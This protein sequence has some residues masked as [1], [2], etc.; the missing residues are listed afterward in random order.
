M[1]ARRI[2]IVVAGVV[3]GV[4]AL[5]VFLRP[6]PGA[7]DV[8]SGGRDARANA[9]SGGSRFLP[10]FLGGGGYPARPGAETPYKGPTIPVYVTVVDL[11]GEPIAGADVDVKA[12]RDEYETAG[13]TDDE[14]EAWSEARDT[15]TTAEGAEGGAGDD[16]ADE[17]GEW[18]SVPLIP[19][20]S[21][22]TDRRGEYIVHLRP[23]VA[24]VFHARDGRGREGISGTLYVYDPA[25]EAEDDWGDERRRHNPS[26]NP[27]RL[28]VTIEIAELSTLSGIVVD[29]RG[30]PIPAAEITLT[31]WSS[32]EVGDESL[33][34][35]D[36]PR[37][38]R[39]GV[40]TG[41]DG[42][43][44]VALRGSGAFDLEAHATGFQYALEQAI[45]ILPGR[46]TIVNLTLL[47]AATLT[48]VVVGPD[49]AGLENSRVLVQGEPTPGTFVS[50]EVT[51]DGAGAFEMEG[52]APGRYIV[53]ASHEGFRPAEIWD[54]VAGSY[55]VTVRLTR[56]GSVHGEV[57]ART[58]ALT[59]LVPSAL[60]HGLEP[61]M[62]NEED[63][64]D[65]VSEDDAAYYG[66]VYVAHR[67]HGEDDLIAIAS[68]V[69]RGK[70]RE[71]PSGALDAHGR[72]FSQVRLDEAGRG[73]FDV[74][75]LPAGVYDVTAM[76]GTAIARIESVRVPDS[77]VVNVRV[78]IPDGS[79]GSIAGTV[80]R[81]DG[82]RP[83]QGTVFLYG[84][85]LPSGLSAV[86]GADGRFD[87]P[88]I[89][90]GEYRV[91]AI[92]RTVGGSPAEVSSTGVNTTAASQNAAYAQA[93]AVVV[94]PSGGRVSIELIAYPTNEP[95]PPSRDDLAGDGV[96]LHA[97]VIIDLGDLGGVGAE[98]FDIE[99]LPVP[100]E[101]WAPDLWIEEIADALVVTSAPPG[102]EGS[103]LF[104]GDRVVSIDGTAVNTL[105]SWQ[106]LELLYG[107]KGSICRIVADRPTTQATISV[108]LVRTR[109]IGEFEGIGH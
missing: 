3:I 82:L 63:S 8:A 70:E 74:E 84:G 88:S 50:Q 2:G 40:L 9:T 54:V 14:Y 73:S 11:A 53:A 19:V 35:D 61:G 24:V 36:A 107:A 56:G 49:G 27:Q 22:R 52:L 79:G 71:S 39:G 5:F 69:P 68:G 83:S 85:T 26:A 106:A 1:S 80:R 47:P 89:P 15:V 77:G 95:M 98:S 108:S 43:F 90:P 93:R 72:Y 6:A 46:E 94:P 81:N 100:G 62:M 104:G 67:G 78:A 18:E 75:G 31:S 44:R 48:G 64:G 105:E 28:E 25:L 59:P 42:R 76:F 17:A 23:D 86:V 57:T 37:G 58:D 29:D 10:W 51:T 101:R 55:A 87:F 66:D 102:P 32:M 33:V 109:E 65:R 96:S 30:R 7:R 45:Q 21:G 34:L 97:D 4:L 20:E 92:L 60:L 38:D 99:D 41:T 16:W 12:D 103:R 91:H 13:L